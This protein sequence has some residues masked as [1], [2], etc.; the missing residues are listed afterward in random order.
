VFDRETW[1]E[2]VHQGKRRLSYD[3]F[4]AALFINL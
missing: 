4:M 2:G 1:D 3:A